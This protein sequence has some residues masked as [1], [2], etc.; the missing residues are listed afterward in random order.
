[1]P[2]RR[3]FLKLTAGAGFALTHPGCAASPPLRKNLFPDFGD[4][5]HPYLGLATSLRVEYDYEARVEGELPAELRGT[6]YRIGPALFDRDGLRRRSLLDGDG[7]VQ[8]FTFHDGGG[9]YRNRFVRTKRYVEEEAAGR[10]IYPSWCTQAPGGLFANFWKAGAVSSQANV[11]VYRRNDRLYAFDEGSLPYELD[12]VTLATVGETSFGLPREMTIYAAHSKV[13]PRTGEW[14][15]FGIRFGPEPRLHVTIFAPDGILRRHRSLPLPR[16]VYM[17]DWFVTD[18]WLV[19]NLQPVGIHFSWF[20]LGLRSMVDSLRWEPGKGNLLMI[21]ERAGDADPVFVEAPASF[22]WHA[23]NAYTARGEIIADYVGYDHPD[24]LIGPDPAAF[25][26]MQGRRGENHYPGTIRRYV[27]DPGRRTVA[28]EPIAGERFE[29]PRV[30]ELHQCYRY[31][32]AYVAREH[33]GEF[34]WSLVS[35]V[36]VTTGKTVQ[37]DFGRGNYCSEPVFIPVPARSYRPD[38]PE[39]PGWLLTEVYESTIRKSHLAVLRA[40]RLADGPLARVHL[41]HHVPFSYHG[42][43]QGAGT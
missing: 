31:R 9:R 30:N 10:F 25:A 6:F 20:L 14:I 37:Y 8:S 3:D 32:F 5:A 35:R 27:I 2:T 36:D 21:V 33:P 23:V 28:A 12:P 16:F 22:M 40:E 24:H 39:E 13:D 41:S 19:F 34:F 7:M 29:W 17:H 15:H 43:W 18:R 4:A 1:M 26:V 11:T 38:D 42:W